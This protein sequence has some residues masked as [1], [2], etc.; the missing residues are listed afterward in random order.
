MCYFFFLVKDWVNLFWEFMEKVIVY[1]VLLEWIGY[2]IEICFLLFEFFK[3]LNIKVF[4][5]EILIKC[6]LVL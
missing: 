3:F 2:F 5:G 6:F 4:L 1:F